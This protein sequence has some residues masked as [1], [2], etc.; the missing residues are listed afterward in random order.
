MHNFQIV[1][2][3]RRHFTYLLDLSSETALFMEYF[4]TTD[5]IFCKA[6]S[7]SSRRSEVGHSKYLV[8]LSCNIVFGS[9]VVSPVFS[10]SASFA[11]TRPRSHQLSPS[12]TPSLGSA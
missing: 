8:T 10:N 2:L 6:G 4:A 7:R 9:S 3:H 12:V 11:T 5:D 1:I